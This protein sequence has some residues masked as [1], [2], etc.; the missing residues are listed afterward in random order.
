MKTKQTL[1]FFIA[2]LATVLVLSTVS[3]IEN[4]DITVNDVEVDGI[5]ILDSTLAGFVSN[6][7]P[8]QIEFTA[9][10]DVEEVKAKVY[11][12]GYKSEISETSER[13]DM[14]N[15]S[16]YSKHFQLTLPSTEDLDDLTEDLTLWVRFSNKDGSFEES[17]AIR[18]QKDSYSLKVLSVDVVNSATAGSVIPVDIVIENNGLHRLD[19]VFVKASIKSLGVERKVFFGDITPNDECDDDDDCDKENTVSKR[20]YLSLPTNAAAGIYD[21]EVEASNYDETSTTIKKIAV[22]EAQAGILSAATSKTIAAG[23]QATFDL[24]LVNP[25]D[26][27]VVYT[28]TPA[29][30]KGLLIT[31]SEPI[32]AVSA[33]SSKTVKITVEATSDAEQGTHLATL[34]VNS[35]AGLVKQVSYSVNVQGKQKLKT[36]SVVVLTIVLAIIFVVLLLVLIVLLSRRPTQTEDFGETSYY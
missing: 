16:T 34:N 7:V 22:T 26:R 5:S 11:I 17:Y 21:L 13:F 33:G 9:N 29:E 25:N 28:I 3:A 14:F 31:V 6:K 35:E 36:N 24:V 15:G 10:T 12:E 20:I 27:I 23:E 8:V 32:A 1:V 4:S 2:L 19:N 30:S 18:M